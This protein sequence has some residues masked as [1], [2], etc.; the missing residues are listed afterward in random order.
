MSTRKSFFE[1]S[2]VICSAALSSEI[3]VVRLTLVV[4]YVGCVV[5]FLALLSIYCLYYIYISF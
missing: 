3:V 4:G 2:I 5:L 1:F